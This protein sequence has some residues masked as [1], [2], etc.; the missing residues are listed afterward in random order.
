M[1]VKEAQQRL[2][3][4]IILKRNHLEGKLVVAFYRSTIA[5]VLTY[6]I[7]AWY[8]NCTVAERK[9]LQRVI[10]TAQH[11]TGCPLLSLEDIAS[12]RCVRRARVITTDPSHQGQHLFTLM[13]SG[14]RYM[15][16]K[17]RTSRL[18][19]F[20]SLGHQVPELIKSV[21]AKRN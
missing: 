19:Q 8:A 1:V 21:Y 9:N 10:N 18:K 12:T 3:F 5:S 15:C 13:P 6:C 7:T 4:L 11:I 16:F 2:H 20:L 14:R 17:S